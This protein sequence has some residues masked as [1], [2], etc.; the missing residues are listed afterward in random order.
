VLL[1]DGGRGY[2]G[3]IF[4]DKWMTSYGFAQVSEEKT[5]TDVISQKTG[6]LPDLVHLHPSDT[7]RDAVQIM[8]QYDVSQLP[9]LTAEP[10][11]VMGEVVGA[12]DERS[13]VDYIF[14]GKAKLTDSIA[15]FIG[16]PLGLIGVHESVSAARAALATADALL[17][18]NDGKPVGV[19]TRQ[20][21]LTFLSD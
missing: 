15:E 14:S 7:V 8:K 13:L 5:V 11:V 12:L 16:A 21:L 3:K 17:V 4:N 20:D 1:P 2:L 19:L 10:P 6:G 18:T 9:I